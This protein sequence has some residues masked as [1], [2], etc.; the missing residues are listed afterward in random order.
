MNEAL[1]P[2]IVFVSHRFQ[3]Q[4]GQGRVNY[5]IVRAALERGF[6]VTM[7]AGFCADELAAH[8]RATFVR[9]GYEWLPT[10]LLKI[11]GFAWS[12][13]RWL[14]RHR[15]EYDL[16]QATGFVTWEPCD[17]VSA[18]FVHA[19][20][21]KSPSYPFH[22]WTPYARYQ[23]LFTTLNARWERRAFRTARRIVAVSEH[24]ARQLC[25]MGMDRE[26]IEVIFNGVD[27]EQFQPGDSERESFRML[28][29]D[30]PV[31]LFVGDIR[32]RRKNL[33]TVLH[34]LQRVPGLYL[35][36]AG[37]TAKSPFPEMALKLGISSRVVF[38]GK[39]PG[40]SALMRSVDLFLFPSRYEAH[41]LVVLEA[42]A[43]GVP[44][45]LSDSFGA[46]DFVGSA[47]SILDDQDDADALA[48]EIRALLECPERR[49][50]MAAAGRQAALG[51][52]WSGMAAQYL[53]L[54]EDMLRV[55][56]HA[57]AEQKKIVHAAY[58]LEES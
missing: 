45:I 30:K 28:P 23:K 33:D 58:S 4:D 36:V 41:P 46:A 6:R 22:G 5:E 14:R 26:R 9:T 15:Q 49:Q 10:G 2:H 20:W 57:A 7:L 8:P 16:V 51:M 18:H 47:A 21:G 40:I 38:L 13:Q 48:T 12:S 43:S 39:V 54:Y 17:V 53:Y 11:L 27:T 19:A 34:A 31:A 44:M 50:E 24:V 25:G 3:M 29:T 55:Q 37:D 56:S 52:Q 42:M 1:Q 35:A 32:T